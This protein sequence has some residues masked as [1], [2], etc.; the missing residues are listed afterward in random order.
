MLLAQP[1]IPSL[2]EAIST[3]I[4]EES[5]IGLQ[6]GAGGLPRVKSAL[7]VSNSGNNGS[8]GETR[9]CYNYGEVGHL[10]Q[11]CT[12]PPRERNSGGQC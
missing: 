9:E 1:K 6:A 12:K 2:N 7:T 8:R 11:A 3:M 4:Q 5:R 10:K